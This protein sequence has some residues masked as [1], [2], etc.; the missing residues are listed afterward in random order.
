MMRIPVLFTST[1]IRVKQNSIKVILQTVKNTTDICRVSVSIALISGFDVMG[2]WA[3]EINSHGAFQ[4][5]SRAL[6]SS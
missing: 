4:A 6:C 2:H 3:K 1:W 5:E